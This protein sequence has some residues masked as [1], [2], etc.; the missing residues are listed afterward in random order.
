[1]RVCEYIDCE[2]QKQCSETLAVA[3]RIYF[4]RSCLL[5]AA[6]D[7][8]VP[9]FLRHNWSRFMNKDVTSRQAAKP[10]DSA[11]CDSR[12]LK[13][14]GNLNEISVGIKLLFSRRCQP[15]CQ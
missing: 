4:N 8:K 7:S 1:V 3:R 15:H 2:I 9:V 13:R 5:W 10:N 11:A 6:G 12:S 14:F